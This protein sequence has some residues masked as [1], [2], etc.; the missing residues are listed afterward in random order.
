MCVCV[1]V[2]VMYNITAI[3]RQ[4]IVFIQFFFYLQAGFG[5]KR[6]IKRR[7]GLNSFSFY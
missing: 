1:C 7:A 4:K 3:Q 6:I 5:T 2:C